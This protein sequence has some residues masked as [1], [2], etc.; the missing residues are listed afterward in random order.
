MSRK[1][2]VMMSTM[3]STVIVLSGCSF[4]GPEK[5]SGPK[6]T[7]PP[8]ISQN[9]PAGSKEVSSNLTPT[10]GKEAA[11]QD[12]TKAVESTTAPIYLMDPDG[13]VVP[14]T[15]NL[16][17][18]EGSAKQILN[19]MV[20]GGPV[21]EL[22]PNGFTAILP[23][24]TK[25]LGMTIK[26]GVA[27]VDFSPEFKKYE[28]KDERKI[29]DAVTYALTSFKSVKEVKIWVN[30]H[31]QDTMPV[32]GTPITSL[33]RDNGINIEL[34]ANVKMGE[35]TP[36]TLYFQAQTAENNTY[37]V[38]VTRLVS[39]TD[40]KAAAIVNELV[41]GPKQGTNL[42]SSILP[43]TKVLNVKVNNGVAVV[44][45]DDKLL[46]F[47]DGKANPQALES[48]VL[49]LTENANVSK[50]QF[51][52]NGKPNVTSGEKDYTKPV[53]RPAELNPGKM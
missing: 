10:D 20:K 52:V 17:K 24:G 40:N 11:Q 7:D 44:D 31:Q 1:A 21:E 43:T 33:S 26:D 38:P 35:T 2:V 34:A 14:V 49:S 15:L 4:F 16:P 41:K 8:Q 28:V 46:S 50:V 30:G 45:F 27:T 5:A 25:V 22:K 42:F 9:K 36:V 18:S 13:Y 3:L 19:Y 53:S 51:L 39:R 12:L 32:G 48:L 47:N 23:E 6:P 29:V 37:Y